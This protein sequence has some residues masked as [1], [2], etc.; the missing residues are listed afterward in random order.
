MNSTS[1][2]GPF[3][4]LRALFG[5]GPKSVAGVPFEAVTVDVP[6]IVS[7][8]RS[9][10]VAFETPARGDGF[11]FLVEVR[12]DWCAEG[13]LD[14]E[15]LSRAIDGYRAA[16]PQR[17]AERVRDVARGYEPFHV[18]EAE[19]AVNHALR[20]GEC[21]ENGLV[22]CRTVA[23]LRPAP[24]VLEQQRRAALELQ[25][26]EHRYAKS[27]L[28]VKLLGEVAE[29]WRSFLAGGLAGVQQDGDA[30]SWLTPW[31]VL[32]A[33]QPD[34][35]ATEVGDMFRQRQE[36]VD[37]FIKI[38]EK[39]VKTYQA[40]DLFEFVVTNEQ[41][42]SHAMRLF[43]LPLPGGLDSGGGVPEPLPRAQPARD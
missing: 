15:G 20:E 22:S 17:L 24:E 8:H 28:Q 30:L 18:E 26:I 41:Q 3:A 38:L 33:E 32:L 40:Q 19:L 31:A 34:K 14:Q 1:R 39:Q 43:G 7:V 4:W 2:R 6:E 35:A 25:D 13:R 5:G 29:K 16:M 36:E 11:G 9:S 42:L 23:H 27:A 12:C 37:K 10:T 21:F